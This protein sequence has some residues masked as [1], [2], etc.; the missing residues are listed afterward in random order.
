MGQTITEKILQ[1][2]TDE[3]N[4]QPGQ[5]I[6][7]RVDIALANDVTAPIALDGFGELGAIGV[8]DKSQV[9]LGPGAFDTK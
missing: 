1:A 9:V 7:A 8:F 6:L 4:I 2:H 3:E 5:F